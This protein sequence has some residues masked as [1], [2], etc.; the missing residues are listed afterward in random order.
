MPADHFDAEFGGAL[1]G[2]ALAERVDGAEDDA[3][4]AQSDGLADGGGLLRH[5]AL[6]VDGLDRPA[7][8]GGGFLHARADAERAAVPLVGGDVDDG[9]AGLRLGAGGGAVP[10]GDGGGGGG[11]M[12]A[13]FG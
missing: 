1:D 4:G 6:A 7:D 8:G 9:L 13:G 11:E 5:G 2:G 3:V 12:G 10:L